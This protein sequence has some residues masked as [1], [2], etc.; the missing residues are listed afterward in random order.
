MSSDAIKNRLIKPIIK[1]Y[2]SLIL[3]HFS[4]SGQGLA[5]TLQSLV[6]IVKSNDPLM[7]AVSSKK[8]SI[9]HAFSCRDGEVQLR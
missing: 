6:K 7:V 9:T 1:C 8:K 3:K 4:A 5:S 2:I